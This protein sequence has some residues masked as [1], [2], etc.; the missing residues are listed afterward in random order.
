MIAEP[1]QGNGGI[2]TP[3]LHYFKA[4]KEV[5][6]KYGILLVIDE[7]QTGFAR[8]GKMFA[9]EHYGVEP[10]V[11]TMAKALGNGVPIA[12]Y[13]TTDEI[14]SSFT[15]PSA[16][17]LGGNPVSAT[18]G[19]AVLEYIE[20]NKL[21]QR[22]ENL[23]KK[24]KQGLIELKEKYKMIGDVRGMGLMIGA[25]LVREGK[26]PAVKET[27]LI[28]EFLKDKGILIGKNGADR[29]VLAFQPPLVI[30]EEDVAALLYHLDEALKKIKG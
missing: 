28:L 18:A 21:C 15:R 5:L 11:M 4:L 16:S 8:T 17:T 24:L 25:E 13:T 10:D 29:N 30:T 26:E 22:A 12:A 6:H 23:G 14:A 3:P 7:I 1:I 27:D 20:E 19:I 9:I 2:I